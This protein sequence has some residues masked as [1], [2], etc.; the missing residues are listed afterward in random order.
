MAGTPTKIILAGSNIIVTWPGSGTGGTMPAVLQ[1]SSIGSYQNFL[2]GLTGIAP[3]GYTGDL[4]DFDLVS[5]D[6]VSGW[7]EWYPRYN[8]TPGEYP[9]PLYYREYS[10][11][12]NAE[13]SAFLLD[14]NQALLS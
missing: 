10:S 5:I 3:N 11:N 14:I 13:Y 1:S 2:A 6:P 9:E 12:F 8:L 4:V 7:A